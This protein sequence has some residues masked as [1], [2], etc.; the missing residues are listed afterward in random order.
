MVIKIPNNI[1]K[2]SDNSKGTEWYIKYRWKIRFLIKTKGKDGS[3]TSRTIVPKYIRYI[4]KVCDYENAIFPVYRIVCEIEDKYHKLLYENRNIA[5]CAIK[6]TKE[7]YKASEISENGNFGITPRYTETEFDETFIPFF[8]GLNAEYTDKDNTVTLDSEKDPNT[9][10]LADGAF[11][12]VTVELNHFGTESMNK[13]I[14]NINVASAEPMDVVGL[15]LS[16]DYA[17]VKGALIDAPDNANSYPYIIIP[18]RNLRNSLHWIQNQW[19]LYLNKPIFFCD[20][21]FF[22]VLKSTFLDHEYLDGEVQMTRILLRTNPNQ[23]GHMPNVCFVEDGKNAFYYTTD[24]I[25]KKDTE[26]SQLSEIVADKT[27]ISNFDLSNNAVDVSQKQ[28]GDKITTKDPVIAADAPLEQHEHSS[29]KIASEY[30]STNNLYNT[31]AN[32]RHMKRKG[33]TTIVVGGVDIRSFSPN[34]QVNLK[35]ID[36]DTV[37]AR[38]NNNYCITGVVFT[39][40][41]ID[42]QSDAYLTTCNAKVGLVLGFDLETSKHSA[43]SGSLTGESNRGKTTPSYTTNY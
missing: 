15:L 27:I 13:K 33:Y 39:F 2:M 4:Q 12:R 11:H 19:G 38:V 22:Y 40:T 25:P 8:H 7:I 6:L 16:K 3:I 20:L 21:G 31:I 26:S 29:K 37:A 18:P 36:N 30:D 35:V 14:Y 17:N 28:S 32:N 43:N 9:N 10:S 24:I 41:P 34:K 42:M 5:L 23:Q 1:R